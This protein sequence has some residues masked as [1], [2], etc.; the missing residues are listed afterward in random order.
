MKWKRFEPPPVSQTSMSK[1]IPLQMQIN[2][3]KTFDLILKL[4]S[5][6][7]FD[8]MDFTISSNHIST[9][10]IVTDTNKNTPNLGITT[11]DV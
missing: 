1:K 7:H 11:L 4:K 2:N 6:A 5:D 9:S 8:S 3:M 10:T